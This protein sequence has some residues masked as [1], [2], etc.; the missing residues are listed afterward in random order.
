MIGTMPYI[1]PICRL[2]PLSV[3]GLLLAQ[4]AI[5]Q[6]PKPQPDILILTDGEKLIGHLESA[7]S[8][9]VKFKS[10]L[11]GEVTV[12]WSKIQELHTSDKYAVLRK[13]EVLKKSTAATSVPQGTVA[14][15]GK[16]IQVTPQGQAPQTIPVGDTA[17]VVEEPSFQQALENPNFFQDWTG[18]VTAG[19]S[20]VEATQNSETFTGAVNLLRAIP[21]VNWLDPLNRTDVNFSASYGKVSQTGTPTVKTSIYHVDAER[22]EFFSPR[23]Y[24]FGE[25]AYD[26]NFSQG[27]NLQQQY[28]GGIGVVAEKSANE[29]LDLKGSVTYIEQSFLK[30]PGQNL[31]GSTFSEIYTRKF[32]KA[33]VFQQGLAITPAWTNS[34]AYSANGNASLGIPLYKRLNFSIGVIDSFLNDPPP[35]FKKNSFQLITGLTYAL[36]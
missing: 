27:L 26:H 9:S 22:D 5:G 13:S 12:D 10:D 3:I 15:A 17:H 21:T 4:T 8:S 36:K 32:A 11:A 1:V 18:G 24:G 14:V 2:Y 25:L 20:L 29:E 16:N 33:I 23:L 30:G 6:T 28:G 34:N 35:T 7:D 19:A 31:F